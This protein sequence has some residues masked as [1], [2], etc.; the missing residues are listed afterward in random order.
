VKKLLII[1]QDEAYFLLETLQVLEKN[2][3]SLKEFETTVLVDEKSLKTAFS[4]SVPLVQGITTNAETA[5]SK[6][7]DVSV[8][9]SLIE[10][11]WDIHA[12]VN[13]KNKIGPTRENG[14]VSVQ[15]LWSSYLMTIK[16]KAPF[17]TFHL[18]DIYKN[19]LG[20]KGVSFSKKPK[21]SIKQ[22]VFG[23]TSTNLFSAVEQET[24]IHEMSLSYP[25]FP[26]KDISEIDLISDLSQ[27]L[28]IGPASLEALKFCEAGGRGIFLSS[29]FQ[30][31]NL[32][33]HEGDHVVL[34]SRGQ[35]FK[36][37][38]LLTFIEREIAGQNNLDTHYSVYKI[39]HEN[40]FGSYLKS[41]NASDDNYPFYQSHVVLWNFL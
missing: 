15:D 9:L 41:C 16:G 3:Q 17:L 2:L 21:S 27:T 30:G 24:L 38:Y 19:I 28:Y 34:S 22:I 8:N 39:D 35:T 40:S 23:S 10:S 13:S 6:E 18:Q 1:Q 5:L 29:A 25:H 26:L 4:D 14:Q 33:P 11:S 37:S 32:I 31:F 12:L 7:Y 36:A 20:F